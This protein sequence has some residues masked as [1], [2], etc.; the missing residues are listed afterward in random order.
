[1]EEAL[2]GAAALTF[3]RSE[4]HGP[5]GLGDV[6]IGEN[7]EESK[8]AA[9]DLPAEGGPDDQVVKGAAGVDLTLKV[10]AALCL[11]DS[12][13][14]AGDAVPDI[15]GLGVLLDADGRVCGGD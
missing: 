2:K 12:D 8:V 1:M 11:R 15:E 13:C 6:T 14:V 5:E 10:V 9:S 4:E 7:R 3:D